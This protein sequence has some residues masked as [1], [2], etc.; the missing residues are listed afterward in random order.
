M[1]EEGEKLSKEYKKNIKEEIKKCL[2]QSLDEY[3]SNFGLFSRGALSV[4]IGIASKYTGNIIDKTSNFVCS[5]IDYCNSHKMDP[6]KLVQVN[7][8]F[9]EL[10]TESKDLLDMAGI[11]LSSSLEFMGTDF[12][13][14]KNDKRLLSV[15]FENFAKKTSSILKEKLDRIRL[16]KDKDNFTKLA[17]IK[18]LLY[19]VT[20]MHESELNRDGNAELLNIMQSIA[21]PINEMTQQIQNDLKREKEI[22]QQEEQNKNA[23]KTT[24][25][26]M[27]QDEPEKNNSDT[28]TK[29]EEIVN[30]KHELPE[31]LLS[32]FKISQEQIEISKEVLDTLNKKLLELGKQEEKI[33]NGFDTSQEKQ[34]D[35]KLKEIND[36]IEAY[37]V[38]ISVTNQVYTEQFEKYQ[39]KEIEYTELIE[40]RLKEIG[41][42]LSQSEPKI[43][44]T[45][46]DHTLVKIT[47]KLVTKNAEKTNELTKVFTVLKNEI[48]EYDSKAKNEENLNSRFD[49]LKHTIEGIKKARESNQ[50]V[51]E[52][53]TNYP[54]SKKLEELQQEA[55]GLREKTTS[56]LTYIKTNKDYIEQAKKDYQELTA[57][58]Y[59]YTYALQI[60]DGFFAEK[61]EKIKELEIKKQELNE[62]PWY[63]LFKKRRI[64][65]DIKNL[66]NKV[67]ISE[68]SYDEVVKIG[69]SLQSSIF[70]KADEIN[71]REQQRIENNELS[72]AKTRVDNQKGKENEAPMIT[73]H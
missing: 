18:P 29:L 58:A 20:Q 17:S 44:L 49:E 33:L 66:E 38:G 22:K 10:I 63:R 71:K 5:L 48:T 2:N 54:S 41:N 39:E 47:E 65:K 68:N 9:N 36:E 12:N 51:A 42:K 69:D 25:K 55:E 52:L 31:S 24:E 1:S 19:G 34:K 26:T 64:K 70:A 45:D 56:D 23:I 67:Q 43:E 7:N 53:N 14:E 60:I 57:Q 16:S 6:E 40:N 73:T 59:Q 72:A 21:D 62:T 13:P 30:K 4:A 37:K 27:Q 11:S 35:E 50:E 46:S 32:E 28:I 8:S 3:K 61:Q 15:M